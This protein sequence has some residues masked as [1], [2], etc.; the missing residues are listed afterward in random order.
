MRR[1]VPLGIKVGIVAFVLV[2]GW[3]YRIELLEWFAPEYVVEQ[4]HDHS[5]KEGDIAY[6]TCPMHPSVKAE[7]AGPCP[8]CGMDLQSVP[9]SQMTMEGGPTSQPMAGA[10]F[11]TLTPWQRQLIGVTTAPVEKKSMQSTLRTV[12]RVAYDETRLADVNLRIRGWIEELYVDYTGKQVRKGQPLFALYSPELVSTQEEYLLALHTLR[13]MESDTGEDNISREAIARQHSLLNAARRRLQLWDL[14]EAQINALD[15][16]RQA[17]RTVT[18]YAPAAGIII[19][20]MAVEG[21]YVTPAMRLYRIASLDV[22]WVHADVYEYELS[23]VHEGQRATVELPYMP[24][25]SFQGRVDYI[26]PYMETKTRT[27]RIRIQVPNKDG[28]LKPDMYAD[29]LLTTASD[30]Q[31]A[32]PENAVLF[33]GLRRVVFVDLGG[34]RFQPREIRLGARMGESYQVLDG[35]KEG[36][37]VVTSAHFLLDSESKLKNVMASMA[38]PYEEEAKP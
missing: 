23:Q 35:L 31:L 1:Y 10:G 27:A 17:Q 19:D 25:K 24:G 22:V 3:I 4:E 30:T 6:W 26:Y 14:N 11:I 7:E 16:E 2:A 9:A 8:I 15:E 32:V 18:I 37:L 21:M 34:G 20:K 28:V 13:S 5:H 36:E 12:G 33:S 38:M 29:V